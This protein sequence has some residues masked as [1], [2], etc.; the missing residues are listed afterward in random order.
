MLIFNLEEIENNILHDAIFLIALSNKYSFKKVYIDKNDECCI[1]FKGRLTEE[2]IK[3]FFFNMNSNVTS[4]SSPKDE[5][6]EYN[7]DYSYKDDVTR[8]Y[9][10]D[11]WKY[12]E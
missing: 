4:E 8:I 1:E 11:G 12:S 2:D 6:V 3:L 10:R 5:K 9:T 7:I